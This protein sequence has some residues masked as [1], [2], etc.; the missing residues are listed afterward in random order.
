MRP[1]DQN[2]YKWTS[3]FIALVLALQLLLPLRYYL[4]GSGNDERFCWRMFSS[5]QL[6]LEDSE[7]SVQLTEMK[8]GKRVIRHQQDL[9][10]ELSEPWIQFL[11]RD[12][13]LVNARVISWWRSKTGSDEVKLLCLIQA[14]D[15]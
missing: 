3:L 11:Q 6:K 4:G 2:P 7:A 13:P 8:D 1:K 14:D 15:D 10:K 12:H 9:A 5:R